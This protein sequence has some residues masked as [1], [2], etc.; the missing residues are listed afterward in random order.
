MCISRLLSQA[1]KGYSQ[2]QKEAL[3]VFWAVK[4]LHKYL[5][6][7]KFTIVTDH[8]AF[9]YVFNP[10]TSTSKATA[11]MV[12]R[13]ALYLSG[14]DYDIKYRL[15]SQI[16]Q[17]D[18]LSRFSKL[19]AA[20]KICLLSEPL[21]MSREDLIRETKKYYHKVCSTFYRGW[22]SATRKRFP[23]LF[24]RREELSMSPD[25][26][27]KMNDCVVIP[28]T[29]RQPVLNEMHK[30]HMGIEK[31]KSLA[32]RM[33]WWPSIGNDIRSTALDCQH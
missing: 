13:W 4:R 11:A 27:L 29:L 14:Y 28:P 7:N 5:F 23:V 31:M 24:K 18:F 1:E 6:G 22:D 9:S 19:G 12:Q 16:P 15:G 25:G 21:P 32:R 3:A 17:A 8:Q 26:V 20:P 30:G 2:T 10:K 33:C